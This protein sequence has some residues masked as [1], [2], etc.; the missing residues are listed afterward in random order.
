[1][2]IPTPAELRAKRIMLGLRQADVARKAGISQSMVARI[3]SGTVDPRVSTLR[4]IVQVLKVAENPSIT[5][6]TVM[7]APVHAVTPDDAITTAVAIMEEEDVSQLPVIENGFPIGCVSES[8]IVN[9]IEQIGI[10]RAHTRKVKDFMESSF[11]TVPPDAD[12]ETV[13]HLLQQ[14]HAVLVL[15]GGKVQGVITKHDLITLIG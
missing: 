12:V 11:P 13:V 9:T 2:Y 5:A 6:G 3:E 8:A 10:A 4:K 14:H 15:G 1:M 7:H